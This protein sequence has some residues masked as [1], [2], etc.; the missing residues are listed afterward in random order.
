MCPSYWLEHLLDICPGVV[1]QDPPVVLCIII[2]LLRTSGLNFSPNSC[3]EMV[4]TDTYLIDYHMYLLF[5]RPMYQVHTTALRVF[6]KLKS[7][8]CML[9]GK[10][11]CKM[12]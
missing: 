2:L 12:K 7:D 6:I 3:I 11:I 4:N 1:L 9:S 10:Q 5:S 8:L